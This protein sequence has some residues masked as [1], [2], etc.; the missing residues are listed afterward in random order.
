M[1]GGTLGI[2]GAIGIGWLWFLPAGL[3]DRLDFLPASTRPPQFNWRKRN[4]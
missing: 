4:L 3:S 1:T 2:A